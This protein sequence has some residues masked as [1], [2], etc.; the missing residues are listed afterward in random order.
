MELLDDFQKVGS[1]LLVNYPVSSASK[2]Y[3]TILQDFQLV[4]VFDLRVKKNWVERDCPRPSEAID[5][6]RA[7][8]NLLDGFG[9]VNI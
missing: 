8:L 2:G 1:A 3:L 5:V 7:G 4:R 9:C 6:L